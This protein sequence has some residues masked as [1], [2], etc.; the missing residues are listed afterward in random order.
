MPFVEVGLEQQLCIDVLLVHA[1]VFLTIVGI[2]Q[3]HRG[4]THHSN[5]RAVLRIEDEGV[6]HIALVAVGLY[7]YFI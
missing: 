1:I 4:I 2:Q 5:V 3:M 6:L 7:T